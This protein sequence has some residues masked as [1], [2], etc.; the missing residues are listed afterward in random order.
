MKEAI[1][2]IP[3]IDTYVTNLTPYPNIPSPQKPKLDLSAKKS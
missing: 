1:V 2:T 3:K